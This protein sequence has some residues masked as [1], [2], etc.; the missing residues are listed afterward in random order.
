MQYF[1]TYYVQ[2]LTDYLLPAVTINKSN[3]STFMVKGARVNCCRLNKW[4]ANELTQFNEET[5][6][7]TAVPITENAC[8][9]EDPS[10]YY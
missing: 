1:Q 4:R 8:Y 3:A 2:F 7:V 6:A 10:I 9:S 5:V